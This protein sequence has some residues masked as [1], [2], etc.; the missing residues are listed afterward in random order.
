MDVRLISG[1]EIFIF[2]IKFA[3]LTT[4]NEKPSDDFINSYT[5]GSDLYINYM[6][7]SNHKGL[8]TLYNISG[9][10]VYRSTEITNGTSK[11]NLENFKTGVYMVKVISDNK[12]YTHKIYVE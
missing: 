10:E 1:K 9:Q 11:F 3:K 2:F 4:N 12:S 7:P 5:S 6:N 8:F